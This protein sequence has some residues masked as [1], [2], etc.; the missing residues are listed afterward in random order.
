MNKV[1]ILSDFD[2]VA[3]NRF[4]QSA[5]K[6]FCD[7]Y[8]SARVTPAV[9][10]KLTERTVK[11]M[12]IGAIDEPDYFGRLARGLRLKISPKEL[13]KY[14]IAADKRNIKRDNKYYG[15]LGRMRA[16]GMAIG[17]ATDISKKLAG[18]LSQA[19]YYGIFGKRYFSHKIG[20]SKTDRRFWRYVLNDLGSDGRNIIFI[21]DDPRNVAA[22]RAAGIRSFLFKNSAQ[23]IKA[24]SKLLDRR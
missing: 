19:G 13:G 9:F 15:W 16:K 12:N 14:M 23:T 6:D 2:G 20:A 21:D 17:M 24:V 1:I 4:T 3:V 11:Q 22:A 7:E 18:R 8:G 10:N 5:I